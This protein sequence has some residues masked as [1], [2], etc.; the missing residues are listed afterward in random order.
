MRTPLVW[1]LKAP[2]GAT[3]RLRNGAMKIAPRQRFAVTTGGATRE[4][5]ARSDA[6]LSFDASGPEP[7]RILVRPAAIGRFAC[8]SSPAAWKTEE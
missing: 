6:T 3:L 8:F 7:V 5:T 1:T 4:I 2:G